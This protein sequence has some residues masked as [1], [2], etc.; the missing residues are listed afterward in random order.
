MTPQNIGKIAQKLNI[1]ENEYQTKARNQKFYSPSATRKILGA[2]GV[3]DYGR[4][5][6]IIGFANNKGGVGKTTTTINVAIKLASLG[7]KVLVIDNDPQAN[8][9]SFF[10]KPRNITFEKTLLDVVEHDEDVKNIIINI[11]DN[12]DLIPS[13]LDTE[14]LTHLFEAKSSRGI[15]A[16]KFRIESFYRNLLKDIDYD[17][18]LWDMNPSWSLSTQYALLSCD[19]V[20]LIANL[21][22]FSTE[23]IDS[24]KKVI[25]KAVNEFGAHFDP[26]VKILLNK[27]DGRLKT[28]FSIASDI[29]NLGLEV[30]DS[31][32]RTDSEFP[33]CQKNK[34]YLTINSKAHADI[35]NFVY[36]LTGLGISSIT[37]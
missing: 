12:L 2:E 11:D 13:R 6:R 32:I 3:Y 15:G 28:S 14:E 36:E 26:T 7:F 29:Q 1:G 33:R 17:Y 30:Y 16:S 35:T 4:N 18:I 21:E 20:I 27:I 24:S 31:T 9:T 23:G 37:Q 22:D 25:A 8:T 5:K 34:T 10:T 19:E